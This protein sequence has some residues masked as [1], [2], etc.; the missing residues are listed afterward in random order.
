M[1]EL[2][3]EKENEKGEYSHANEMSGSINCD[4]NRSPNEENARNDNRESNNTATT[5]LGTSEIVDSEASENENVANRTRSQ[6]RKHRHH[7][8]VSENNAIVINILNPHTINHHPTARPNL[9]HNQQ[10]P[11]CNSNNSNIEN[12]ENQKSQERKYHYDNIDRETFDFR[13]LRPTDM[14]SS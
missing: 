14:P 13:E 8:R 6:T 5:T 4:T 11:S 9:T 1:W 10:L 3:K 7:T 2:K 12:K